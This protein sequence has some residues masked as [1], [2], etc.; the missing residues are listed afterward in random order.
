MLCD[1]RRGASAFQACSPVDAR[2][3]RDL[4]GG[5]SIN[6]A[7][8]AQSQ[9]DG[10]NG[11]RGVAVFRNAQRLRVLFVGLVPRIEAC[12]DDLGLLPATER[13]PR[14]S[15]MSIRISS[16][17]DFIMARSFWKSGHAPRIRLLLPFTPHPRGRRI[18]R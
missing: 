15:T 18:D 5:Q 3:G 1:I 16:R 9:R 4:R 7:E 12:N 10:L 13:G 6:P 2:I 11:E 14:N 8:I 17:H